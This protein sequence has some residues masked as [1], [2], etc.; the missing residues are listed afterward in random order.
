MQ[1]KLLSWVDLTVNSL[2]HIEKKEN[3][4]KCVSGPFLKTLPMPS[5][6]NSTSPFKT[7]NIAMSSIEFLYIRGSIINPLNQ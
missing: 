4:P 2:G 7:K 3:S 6:R 1:T 5:N